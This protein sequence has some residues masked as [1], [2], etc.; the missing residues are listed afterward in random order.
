M[1]YSIII[2]MDFVTDSSYKE[3]NILTITTMHVQLSFIDERNLSYR[4]NLNDRKVTGT[5][6]SHHFPKKMTAS[7]FAW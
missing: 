7:M 1:L 3:V 4:S 6:I 2:T 5:L